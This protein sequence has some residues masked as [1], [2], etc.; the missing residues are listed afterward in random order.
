[1]KKIERFLLYTN[2]SKDTDLLVTT[3]LKNYIE[4]KGGSTVVVSSDEEFDE[5]DKVREELLSGIDAIIVLGGDG[6]ILRALHTIQSR[7]I[8]IIGI[9]LGTLGFLTEVEQGA[10]TEAVDRMMCGDYTVENRMLLKAKIESASSGE[11]S[12]S[13]KE[14][15]GKCESRK[16]SMLAPILK[17]VEPQW[18]DALNDIVVIRE[19]VLRLIALRVYLNGKLFDTYEADGLIVSTPTGSTGYNLSCGGP[20]CSPKSRVIILTAVSPHSMSKK[21]IV[22]DA[23]DRLRIELIEKRK[24]Q[25][26]EAIVSYDGYEN[27]EM[28]V[29]DA[30]EIAASDEVLRLIRIQD[31]TFMEALGRKF[32]R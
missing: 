5:N 28:S 26:N 9:N 22:F 24:T 31:T 8:P 25:E 21:S 29:G 4:E 15:P 20:I 6:T 32:G 1:M 30:V 14:E 27:F 2:T 19:G 3:K 13:K 18:I 23:S 17:K 12:E 16:I 7:E 10:M 11:K